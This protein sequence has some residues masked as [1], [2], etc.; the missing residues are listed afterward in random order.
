VNFASTS[1]MS[2]SDIVDADAAMAEE[3][4]LRQAKDLAHSRGYSLE[5]ATKAVSETEAGRQLRD[6][7]N[8]E[9][10]HEKAQVWQ[11]SVFCRMELHRTSHARSKG[12][13]RPRVRAEFPTLSAYARAQRPKLRRLWLPLWERACL[14]GTMRQPTSPL[15]QRSATRP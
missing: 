13:G 2:D 3:V 14:L 5:D 9:H 15:A 8:G 6:L 10:R 12:Y 11:A 4:L 7:A 1:S